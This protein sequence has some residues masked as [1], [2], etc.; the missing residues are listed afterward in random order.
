MQRV[1]RYDAEAQE[2]RLVYTDLWRGEH[3]RTEYRVT[4]MRGG[5]PLRGKAFAEM[6]GREVTGTAPDLWL[7]PRGTVQATDFVPRV[8]TES[9]P[10][11]PT[12]KTPCPRAANPRRKCGLCS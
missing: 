4:D 6:D 12:V 11:V 8:W 7:K 2:L 5:D 1:L 9:K 3:E 10:V